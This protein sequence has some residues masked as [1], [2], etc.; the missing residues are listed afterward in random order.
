MS[1]ESVGEPRAARPT[2]PPEVAAW[3][4]ARA[5]ARAE[6]DWAEADRLR[7]LIEAAG[8]K[9]V[10]RGIHF[11][12]SPAHPPDV[13]ESGRVRHGASVTVPSRLDEPPTDDATVVLVATDWPDDLARALAGL[14]RFAPAGTSVVIVANDPSAEQVAELDRIESGE[15]S[16]PNLP[17]EVVWTSA[18]LGHA[19]ALNAGLRRASGRVVVVMDTSVEPATDVVSPLVAALGDPTVGVAG[20]F[21]VTSTNLRHFEDAPAGEVDAIEGYLMAFRRDDIGAR[22]PLDEHFRFYR[23]LDLWWSLALRDEGVDTPPRRAVA[24]SLPVQRHEHRDWTRLDDAER[25]RLSKRNYYRILD[26][27]GRRMDLLGAARAGSTRT[28]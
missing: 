14:K 24:L 13:V 27:F 2:A 26:R 1:G 22:G 15:G 4:H 28:G 12:L 23:N 3:A 16:Q 8:W 11:Q 18:R 7:E 25:D 5:D 19:T 21:G 9:V 17:V 10:D 20:A 6:R